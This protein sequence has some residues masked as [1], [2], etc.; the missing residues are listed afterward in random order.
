MKGVFAAAS[1]IILMSTAA[2]RTAYAAIPCQESAGREQRG[3]Y[4]SWREIDGKRCWFVSKGRAMPP[5]S[6]FTWVTEE[7]TEKALEQPAKEDVTPA[8]EKTKTDPSIRVRILRVKPVNPEELS[9]GRP[10]WVG[11]LPAN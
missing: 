9:D 7:P 4:W 6:V 1:A 11:N 2:G 10:N 5:K 3:V 8:P